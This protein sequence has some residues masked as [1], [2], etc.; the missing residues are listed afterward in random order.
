VALRFSTE[1]IDGTRV[2]STGAG[3]LRIP[4]VVTRSGVFE[5]RDSSGSV[6]REWRPPE[7]VM[8]ADSI[9]SMRDLPV[10]IR[11]PKGFVDPSSWQG[12]AIGHVSNPRADDSIKAAG[13]DIVISRADAQARVGTDLKEISYGYK[14]RI[15]ATPGVVPDGYPDAGKFYDVVQ[16]DIVG[17][18]VA[19][20][21]TG[22]GRQGSAVS[23][24]L[25]SAGDECPPADPTPQKKEQR[26][27][28]IR[29]DGKEFNSETE[30]GLQS[31]IDAH[32]AATALV[33]KEAAAA[34]EKARADA[35]EAAVAKLTAEVVAA[36]ADAAAAPAKLAARLGLE[37]EAKSLLGNA[38]KFDGKTDREIRVETI[39]KFDSSYSDAGQTDEAVS[40]AYGVWSKVG[41]QLAKGSRADSSTRAIAGALGGVTPTVRADGAPEVDPADADAARA[42]RAQRNDSGTSAFTFTRD[43]A[44]KQQAGG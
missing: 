35:A 20:G 26:M 32:V 8:K 14:V 42:R 43:G 4:G 36:R 30:A 24:R 15:D 44:V 27:F 23:L 7:E 39:K 5:Y 21:P 19:L 13:A 22:W 1:R 10:T 2:E 6:V 38:A 9:A 11:H 31:Q 3:G 12:L 17:N 29:I 18:H 34:T 40:A 41:V 37:T 25:D 16:R 28:K 33:A